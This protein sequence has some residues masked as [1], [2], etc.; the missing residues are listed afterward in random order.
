MNIKQARRIVAEMREDQ[1]AVL[2]EAHDRYMYFA[3]VYTDRLNVARIA[4]DRAR[5][6]HLLTF[7]Q[8]GRSSLSDERCAEF[9][10]AITGLPRDWCAAWDEVEFANPH[11]EN[12]I[13][14]Q[15]FEAD[16]RAWAL[17]ADE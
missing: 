14:K 1:H 13:D 15:Q 4:A 6:P 8:D 11:G 12:F 10:S 17:L 3:G 2:S 7:T 5:F 16:Q 9:M